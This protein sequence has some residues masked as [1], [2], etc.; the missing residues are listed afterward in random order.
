MSEGRGYA[1][2]KID[3]P[4]EIGALCCPQDCWRLTLRQLTPG[5]SRMGLHDRDSEYPERLRQPI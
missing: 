4:S 3:E 2:P 1:P 5:H